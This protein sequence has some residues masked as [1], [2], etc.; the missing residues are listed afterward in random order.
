MVTMKLP[1]DGEIISSYSEIVEIL[2]VVNDNNEQDEIGVD[3]CLMI[4]HFKQYFSA[5]FINLKC[6][7]FFKVRKLLK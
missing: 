1:N 7:F 4:I 2:S 6:F 3:L 5:F